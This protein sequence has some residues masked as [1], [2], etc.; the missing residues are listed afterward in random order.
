MD[1][2]KTDWPGHDLRGKGFTKT[3][4]NRSPA[5]HKYEVTKPSTEKWP[6]KVALINF[7]DD[8]P[9]NFG[10]WVSFGVDTARI[11]VYVD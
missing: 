10:G 7:C 6:E 11:D 4:T 2:F 8:G 5:T 9:M 3:M 1:E